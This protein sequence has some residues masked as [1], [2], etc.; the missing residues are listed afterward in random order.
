VIFMRQRTVIAIICCFLGIIYAQET[1]GYFQ[2]IEGLSESANPQKDWKES[3]LYRIPRG[4]NFAFYSISLT[5]LLYKSKLVFLW[6]SGLSE[7]DKINTA[8][9]TLESGEPKSVS[10]I[11]FNDNLILSDNDQLAIRIQ[12]RM[13]PLTKLSPSPGILYVKGSEEVQFQP[14]FSPNLDNAL[15]S[16][17]VF[18]Y[19][20]KADPKM[21]I[22]R[23]KGFYSQ[24]ATFR[25]SPGSYTE[26]NIV[27]KSYPILALKEGN[28][29]VQLENYSTS[30]EKLKAVNDNIA[31]V[32]DHIK[33]DSILVNEYR[34]TILEGASFFPTQ[35]E[36]SNKSE[37]E[38]AQQAYENEKKRLLEEALQLSRVS[39]I[40]TQKISQYSILLS[41]RENIQNASQRERELLDQN[42]VALLVE[43]R[44]A[45]RFF[46]AGGA[47]MGRNMP[48]YAVDPGPS[49]T[50]AGY[51]NL[52]WYWN[53]KSYLLMVPR[54]EGMISRWKYHEEISEVSEQQ[55]LGSAF[56]LAVP[57]VFDAS[58]GK[59]GVK[60]MCLLLRAGGIAGYSMES[61]VRA[62]ESKSYNAV[63]VGFGLGAEFYFTSL[64]IGI[65]AEY[66]YHHIGYGDLRAGFSVPLWFLSP[67][68]G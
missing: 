67:L 18:I 48:E 27:L 64:P 14:V 26:R 7:K 44:F 59:D 63:S 39:E 32:L 34:R 16:L 49:G 31:A 40:K 2:A 65:H 52:S 46:L 42:P 6:P 38:I 43:S 61:V 35:N 17:P 54:L 50:W 5:S 20:R 47:S 8:F 1:P 58:A 24:L 19:T 37:Y 21:G 9:F 25:S 41:L 68:G 28:Y 45:G 23:R 56:Y 55:W 22:F 62:G 10:Q 53:F 12:G 66:Q 11:I 29:S 13:Q 36:F 33:R 51:V 4:N 15:F 57:L 60:G 3:F 30:A